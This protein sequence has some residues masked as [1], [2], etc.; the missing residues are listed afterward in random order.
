MENG[1]ATAQNRRN[2]ERYARTAD[3]LDGLYALDRVRQ[4]VAA[5]ERESRTEYVAAVHDQLSLEH[6][7]WLAETAEAS[8]AVRAVR[9]LA[10][11]LDRSEPG[12]SAT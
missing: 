1:E 9:A 7:Q 5:G 3:S 2:A 10:E 8:R 4:A 11:R 12:V 6:R